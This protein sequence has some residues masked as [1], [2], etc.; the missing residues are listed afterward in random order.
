MEVLWNKCSDINTEWNNLKK[1]L[2]L[3]EFDQKE[4]EHAMLMAL[5][6]EVVSLDGI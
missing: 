3:A 1:P 5:N 4:D 2:K 6:S